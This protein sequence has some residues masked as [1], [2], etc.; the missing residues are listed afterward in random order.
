MDYRVKSAFSRAENI[1]NHPVDSWRE[2]SNDLR[3]FSAWLKGNARKKAIEKSKEY[4]ACAKKAI[5]NIPDFVFGEEGFVLED[6]EE[7]AEY[8]YSKAEIYAKTISRIIPYIVGLT[9]GSVYSGICKSINGRESK[10]RK[11]SDLEKF[12]RDSVNNIY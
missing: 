12:V 6:R 7:K 4:S 1:C 9:I 3:E 10:C 5:K 8:E 11:W 2:F